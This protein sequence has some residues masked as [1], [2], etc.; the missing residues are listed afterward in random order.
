LALPPSESL[1][2]RAIISPRPNGPLRPNRSTSAPSER[3]A[4]Q[5]DCL[6]AIAM[7]EPAGRAVTTF[8]RLFRGK[9]MA[10]GLEQNRDHRGRNRCSA[11]D[12]ACGGRGGLCRIPRSVPNACGRRDQRPVAFFFAMPETGGDQSSSVEPVIILR[13]KG[14]VKREGAFLPSAAE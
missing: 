9:T 10:G 11:L 12:H 6:I 7:L 4:T 3:S 5:K 8:S 2:F 14:G 13:K 1:Q